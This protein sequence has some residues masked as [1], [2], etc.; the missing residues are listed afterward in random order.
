M[1]FARGPRRMLRCN[2]YGSLDNEVNPSADCPKRPAVYLCALTRAGWTGATEGKSSY[3][4]LIERFYLVV[5]VSD[6]TARLE[7][8][9]KKHCGARSL[10][11]LTLAF[12]YAI[13]K[14]ILAKYSLIYLFLNGIWDVSDI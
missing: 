6:R 7:G 3:K 11:K 13:L 12:R 2:N 8:L 10:T 5:S 14:F 9:S 1:L 4:T